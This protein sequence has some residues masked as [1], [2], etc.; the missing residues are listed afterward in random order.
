MIQSRKFTKH[1]IPAPYYKNWIDRG[2]QAIHE[3]EN[4]G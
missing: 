3:L 1:V 4:A 2:S